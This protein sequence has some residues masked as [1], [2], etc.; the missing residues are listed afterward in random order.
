MEKFVLTEVKGDLGD[1]LFIIASSYSYS[2]RENATL[3]ILKTK[4]SK[5]NYPVYWETLLKKI[6][7]YLIEKY[8]DNYSYKKYKIW[9]EICPISYENIVSEESIYLNGKMQS[10]KYFINYK[11][12]IKYLFKPESFLVNFTRNKYK[13][14]MEQKDRV[15]VI[16]L[17]K[18]Q[19]YNDPSFYK[20]NIEYY[21]K[22][23]RL[24]VDNKPN[25]L[26]LLCV[27][28]ENE[29]LDELKSYINNSE[30]YIL[31]DDEFITFTLLQEFNNFIMSNCSFIW[32]CIWLS[33]F[34]NVIV[35]K[36]WYN[37]YKDYKDFYDD[38][39]IQID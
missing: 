34:K 18:K 27:E 32:W 38:K 16:Y 23:I 20:I 14:L 37:N 1:Q 13:F 15:I 24:F 5:P 29:L 25:P 31:K 9:N 2:K 3:N 10:Y 12:D 39:W 11:E 7:P 28:E 30:Y 8:P 19:Y 33:D 6:K 22:A 26:F 17:S 36:E 4:K 35:P 21:K